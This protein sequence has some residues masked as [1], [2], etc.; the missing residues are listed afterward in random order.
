MS[1]KCSGA[2]RFSTLINKTKSNDSLESFHP[3]CQLTKLDVENQICPTQNTVDVKK[4]V[5]GIG[6][7]VFYIR[8]VSHGDNSCIALEIIDTVH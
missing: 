8:M 1:I 4:E 3:L 5:S 7:L 6:D 2:V